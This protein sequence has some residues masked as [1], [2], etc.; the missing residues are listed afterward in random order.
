[1]TDAAKEYAVAL[2]ELAGERHAEKEVLDGLRT[3]LAAFDAQPEYYS[4]LSAPNLSADERDGLLVAAFEEAVDE[5]ALTATRLF[6]RHG[7]VSRFSAFVR[8]YEKMFLALCAVSRVKVVSAVEMTPEEKT[9]LIAKLEKLSRQRVE[10]VYETD[11][12]I[13]GGVI[14]TMDD[15]II[16]GSLRHKLNEMKE[17]LGQ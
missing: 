4:V 17:V 15:R 11:P 8:E 5:Q 10:A 6:C 1:M 3:I 14:V 12:S 9:A 13:L 7:H 16:D 2:F